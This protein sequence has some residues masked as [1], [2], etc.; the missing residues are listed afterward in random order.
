MEAHTKQA[1]IGSSDVN[2]DIIEWMKQT[3]DAIELNE[4][5]RSVMAYAERLER[6]DVIPEDVADSLE[7]KHPDAKPVT[8]PLPTTDDLPYDD[9]HGAVW[10]WARLGAATRAEIQ[11]RL[12]RLHSNSNISARMRRN[13]VRILRMNFGVDR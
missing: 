8:G 11:Q 6:G 7:I 12:Q 2:E 3:A 10:A 13:I 5:Y 1:Q 9:S 4:E